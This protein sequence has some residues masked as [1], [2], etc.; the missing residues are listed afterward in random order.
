MTDEPFVEL[1]DAEIDALER[2]IEPYARV[3]DDGL[4]GA[5]WTETVRRVMRDTDARRLIVNL[6]HAREERETAQQLL[7]MMHASI[8]DDRVD[9]DGDHVVAITMSLED[10]AEW[11]AVVN[12]LFSPC[13]VSED[14]ESPDA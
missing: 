11:V 9:D 5:E 13:A 4:G 12:S 2:S 3:R 7:W 1:T 6:R 14:E 10:Y 8:E